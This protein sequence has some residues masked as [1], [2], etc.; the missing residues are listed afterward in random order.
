M[1]PVALTKTIGAEQVLMMF[2]PAC[3]DA[4]LVDSK[5]AWDGNLETPTVSPS[6]LVTQVF[7]PSTGISD[8]RCHSFLTDGHWVFLEDCTHGLAGQTVPLPPVPD[9][10][11]V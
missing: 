11:L 2:C 9:W 7:H 1:N 10:M 5:W 3:D 4:H 6:I 8:R